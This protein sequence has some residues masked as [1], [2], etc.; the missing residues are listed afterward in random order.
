MLDKSESYSSGSNSGI[1]ED[2]RANL[3]RIRNAATNARFIVRV[4]RTRQHDQR[5]NCIL[6]RKSTLKERLLREPQVELQKAVDISRYFE[7]SHKEFVN[8]AGADKS[9]YKEVDV[10]NATRPNK[11]HI[12]KSGKQGASRGRNFQN[13]EE[14]EIGNVWNHAHAKRLSSLGKDMPKF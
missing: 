8:I 10:L 1:F 3:R 5:Q 6:D 4:R 11:G 13:R 12:P 2:L 14:D 7:L 9:D